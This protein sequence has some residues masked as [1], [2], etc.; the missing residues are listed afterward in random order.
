MLSET[1][2]FIVPQHKIHLFNKAYNYVKILWCYMD[3]NFSVNAFV[4]DSGERYCLVVDR[5]SNLPEYYTNLF[6]TTQMR[7]R[8]MLLQ[9]W[10]PQ[11]AT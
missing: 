1:T 6:L 5:S 4:I 8:G 3:K 9:L 10:W 11:P 7:N 2:V